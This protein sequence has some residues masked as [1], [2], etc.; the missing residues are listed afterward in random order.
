MR[1]TERA[2]DGAKDLAE[3]TEVGLVRQSEIVIRS[4]LRG[5]KRKTAAQ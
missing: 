4:G 3:F 2:F 5:L 1:F